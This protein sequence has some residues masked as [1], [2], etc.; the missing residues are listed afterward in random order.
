MA[1][2]EFSSIYKCLPI[3][4]VH[5]LVEKD[6]PEVIN[7]IKAADLLIYQPIFSS[8]ARPETLSSE[9]LISKTKYGAH[10]ISFPSIYFNGYFPHLDSFKGYVNELNLVHDYF[11]A[12]SCSIGFTEK[13]T[14]ELIQKENLYPKDLSLRLVKQSL[15]NL[16]NRETQFHIDI[17]LSD[18]IEDNYRHIKLFNTF[19]HP[20]KDIFRYTAESIMREIGIENY[21][22]NPNDASN[23]DNI[24]APV[25][26]STYKNL[27]L[28]FQENFNNYNTLKEQ[29]KSQKEVVSEFF[30][31]YKR[32]NPDEIK[33]HVSKTKPFVP[34]LINQYH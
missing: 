8:P 16:K 30:K 5:R 3:K 2:K 19:N 25:H 15:K 11:I 24:S 6:V 27:K 12:Y 17:K 26:K 21:S 23:L 9:F 22:I 31:F 18:F 29:G 10:K 28:D 4:P 20:N 14:I 13:E 33:C 34:Q 7:K 32:L 1:N